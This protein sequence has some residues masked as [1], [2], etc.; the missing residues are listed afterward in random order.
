MALLIWPSTCLIQPFWY[1][2]HSF[3]HCRKRKKNQ[4][5]DVF[6]NA[7]FLTWLTA[8]H[9]PVNYSGWWAPQQT[10]P[11]A[12]DLNFWLEHL[13]CWHSELSPVGY[14]FSSNKLTLIETF[15]QFVSFFFFF[16]PSCSENV[17][18]KM[19][20]YFLCFWL[21]SV[22]FQTFLSNR[23]MTVLVGARY[24]Q[25]TGD[26]GKRY[27]LLPLSCFETERV[28]CGSTCM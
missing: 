16:F 23:K 3:L 14:F 1:V 10:R 13:L 2:I 27:L 19:L 15:R 5:K 24:L 7:L 25:P 17:L 28:P 12:C 6:V 21:S 18:P 8:D 20:N 22:T 9:Q 4:T 11:A 26:C